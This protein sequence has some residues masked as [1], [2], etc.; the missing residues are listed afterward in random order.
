MTKDE[1]L[2]A[3]SETKK[4]LLAS[5]GRI[6]MKL[7]QEEGRE[8]LGLLTSGLD[9]LVSGGGINPKQDVSDA[10]INYLREKDSNL[11][12]LIYS[13][14]V[15]ESKVKSFLNQSKDLESEEFYNAWDRSKKVYEGTQATDLIKSLKTSLKAEQQPQLL[16]SVSTSPIP[17]IVPTSSIEDAELPR[18]VGRGEYSGGGAGRFGGGDG[19]RGTE[20]P[21]RDLDLF[22]PDI[23]R[24]GGGRRGEPARGGDGWRGE[25]AGGGGDRR[26]ELAGG[27]DGRRVAFAGGVEAEGGPPPARGVG[28]RGAPPARGGDGR[29]APPAD[30]IR[31][32]DLLRQVHGDEVDRGGGGKGGSIK[33]VKEF[34]QKQVGYR[35]DG[36]TGAGRDLAGVAD[37]LLA[38]DGDEAR[39]RAS[40]LVDKIG[41]GLVLARSPS[42]LQ[43]RAE[44]R[45]VEQGLSPDTPPGLFESVANRAGAL[46]DA[47]RHTLGVV[48]DAV[49][50]DPEGV[51]ENAQAVVRDLGGGLI[52]GESA[53]ERDRMAIERR[54][55]E[56]A[57][58]A[59][60]AEAQRAQRDRLVEQ[61]KLAA[62]LAR[63][64]EGG[65]ESSP[66]LDPGAVV[67]AELG[68]QGEEKLPRRASVMRNNSLSVDDEEDELKLAIRNSDRKNYFKSFITNSCSC[69]SCGISLQEEYTPKPPK[70]SFSFQYEDDLLE[71]VKSRVGKAEEQIVVGSVTK[72]LS[73]WCT[74][75]DD[76]IDKKEV[77]KDE[78]I[79]ELT[80]ASTNEARKDL[81]KNTLFRTIVLNQNEATQDSQKTDGSQL[82]T[83]DKHIKIGDCEIKEINIVD[84]KSKGHQSRIYLDKNGV[85][86]IK[87]YTESHEKLF[88]KYFLNDPNLTFKNLLTEAPQ[89]EPSLAGRNFNNKEMED[90]QK[91]AS[92]ASRIL[93]ERKMER[94]DF[95]FYL[96]DPNKEIAYVKVLRE[97][98]KH[99]KV[100]AKN[101]VEIKT[102]K[103]FSDSLKHINIHVGDSDYIQIHLEDSNNGTKVKNYLSFFRKDSSNNFDKI[104]S[105]NSKH[106]K[107]SKI[108]IISHDNKE[109][110]FKDGDIKE[111]DIDPEEKK[112]SCFSCLKKAKPKIKESGVIRYENDGWNIEFEKADDSTTRCAK[113]IINANDK[114]SFDEKDSE[115]K[116]TADAFRKALGD[117]NEVRK[118]KL[119]R[120]NET[121]EVTIGGTES[122][123]TFRNT[124]NLF[125]R[126]T[127]GNGIHK[128]EKISGNNL[129]VEGAVIDDAGDGAERKSW[130]SCFGR[131]G[132]GKKDQVKEGEGE[133]ERGGR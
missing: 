35:V 84:L 26:D 90:A 38:G 1:G 127:H 2:T 77:N 13:T 16:V 71:K 50:F 53:Q 92:E 83:Q 66:R 112:S 94:G 43:G 47:S 81:Q 64:G 58:R 116:K 125:S 60:R 93:V 18:R 123:R 72:P 8:G 101:K 52:D 5:V 30:D 10:R 68:F 63:G 98:D 24:G 99:D 54:R 76:F 130:T 86:A 104:E 44:E 118:F 55:V 34:A 6:L 91:K 14:T 120:D 48:V 59:E 89:D 85:E 7:N 36:L 40:D 27:G 106:I 124:A 115:N 100:V 82:K 33:A 42:E 132:E 128:V 122:G 32:P 103:E 80:F 46:A 21:P 22:P 19:G 113:L 62:Q 121:Y 25:P 39:M 129:P 70:K 28:G 11:Y 73:Q 109:T 56:E 96:D 49:T 74:K 78:F 126:K 102:G 31:L 114:I 108:T 69:C 20:P 87:K 4:Q 117:K 79:S 17:G 37:A 119:L 23:A 61:R 110:K 75:T 67:D 9:R 3:I 12:Q 95:K 131:R 105:K 65:P 133:E 45:R 15:P 51:K 57:Q 88:L 107:N 97:I 111:K 29:G 41:R